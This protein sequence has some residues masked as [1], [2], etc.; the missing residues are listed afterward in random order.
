MKVYIQ[1]NELS[2]EVNYK[3]DPPNVS[4]TDFCTLLFG[5]IMAE[6]NKKI[7]GK[8]DRQVQLAGSMSKG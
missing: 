3:T 4:S 5:V 6:L 8:V 7:D 2:G 1:V